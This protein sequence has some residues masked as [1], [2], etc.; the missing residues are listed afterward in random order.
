[1]GIYNTAVL[2]NILVEKP[3]NSKK[4]RIGK[5]NHAYLCN[6]IHS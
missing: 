4:I 2:Y 6:I 1:M 5:E 3:L